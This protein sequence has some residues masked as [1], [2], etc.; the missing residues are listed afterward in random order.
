MNHN[1]MR[2][3][4]RQGNGYREQ[5]CSLDEFLAVLRPRPED[6]HLPFATEI[7]QHIPSGQRF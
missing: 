5:D 4:A 7:R 1:D 2:P 3:G 6:G